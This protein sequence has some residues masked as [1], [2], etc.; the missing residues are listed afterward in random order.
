LAAA[1]V[2][3]WVGGGT[4]ARTVGGAPV[5]AAAAVCVAAAV[6]VG[7]ALLAGVATLAGLVATQAATPMMINR[8]KMAPATRSAALN[9]FRTCDPLL[10]RTAALQCPQR[11]TR[12]VTLR[13]TPMRI[14]YRTLAA[15][16]IERGGRDRRAVPD[17]RHNG[18]GLARGPDPRRQLADRRGTAAVARDEQYKAGPGGGRIGG[19]AAAPASQQDTAE[20]EGHDDQHDDSQQPA[21]ARAESGQACGGRRGITS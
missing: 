21:T 20:G 1:G 11:L 14:C 5:L 18:G 10:T 13:M 16:W 9:R 15:K 2:V 12:C 8:A 7:V 4:A 6:R 17:Q 3:A 19:R